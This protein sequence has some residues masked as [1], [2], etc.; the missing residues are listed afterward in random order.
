MCF[1]NG[2]V[3]KFPQSASIFNNKIDLIAKI[4]KYYFAS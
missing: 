3:D 1:H 2:Q 4:L